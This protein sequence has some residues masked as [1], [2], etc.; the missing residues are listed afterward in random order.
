MQEAEV[1]SWNYRCPVANKNGVKLPGYSRA[2]KQMIHGWKRIQFCGLIFVTSIQI[3]MRIF[4]NFWRK[5]V[6]SVPKSGVNWP[7]LCEI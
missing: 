5:T 6:I 4:L 1:E 3:W 2:T 7:L